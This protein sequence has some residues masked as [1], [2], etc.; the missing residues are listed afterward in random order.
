MEGKEYPAI[1]INNYHVT[2]QHGQVCFK[3]LSKFLN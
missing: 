3:Q 2:F 1:E